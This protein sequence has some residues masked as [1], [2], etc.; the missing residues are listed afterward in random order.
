MK[1]YIRPIFDV[2]YVESEDIITTSPNSYDNVGT[3]INWDDNE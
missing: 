2:V 1:N 3:D